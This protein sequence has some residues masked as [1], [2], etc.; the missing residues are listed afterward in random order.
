MASANAKQ[1]GATLDTLRVELKVAMASLPDGEVRDW[2]ARSA[3]RFGSITWRRTKNLGGL[4][5]AAGQGVWREVSGSYRAGVEGRLEPHLAGRRDAALEAVE[6]A[7]KAGAAAWVSTKK[8]AAAVRARPA[9]FAPEL[10]GVGLGFLAGSGGPDGDGGV[11]DLDLLA[12]IGAHRSIFTHSIIGGAMV[13]ATVVATLD[14]VATTYD[15][16][17]RGHHPVWDAVHDYSARFGGTFVRGADVG[18]GWHLGI[19]GTVDG[20]TPY[21]DLPTSLSMEGH[22]AVLWVNAVAE[23]NEGLTSRDGRERE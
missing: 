10:L 16:L 19:D 11:P 4:L 20:M 5:A 15:H 12:G 18:I 3:R 7:G 22:R 14:L 17:P 9:E 8:L 1:A 23:V 6:D 13:E 21:K 2:A